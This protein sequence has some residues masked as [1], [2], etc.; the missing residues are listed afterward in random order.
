MRG[1]SATSLGP[2]PIGRLLRG[3]VVQ[4]E[5]PVRYGAI[6]RPARAAQYVRM[7]SDHQKYS[8]QNQADVIVAYAAGRGLAIVRTCSDE[9]LSGLGIGWRDGLK[10]LIADVQS[11]RIDFDCVL[12][13][14]V[15]RWGRFQDVD[16]SAYY[17]FICRRAGI[18]VHYCADEFEN[19]G[20]LASII[21]KNV[22]RG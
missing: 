14:D 15:S 17:E 12:V 16:E 18:A 5:L 6:Q 22:K 8:T 7:S 21:L 19:D 13:Y 2:T 1:L 4:T 20:S 9:G 10:Q 11:E 3:V